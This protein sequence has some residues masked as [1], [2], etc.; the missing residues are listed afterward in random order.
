MQLL[1]G[2]QLMCS[3]SSMAAFCT[4]E[5]GPFFIDQNHNQS[6]G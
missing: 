2:L 4:I 1:Q 5:G 6:H 3:I